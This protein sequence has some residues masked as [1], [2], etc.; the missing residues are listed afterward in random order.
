[1]GAEREAGP[2]PGVKVVL[3]IDTAARALLLADGPVL[4]KSGG[5]VDG[6]LVDALGAVDVVDAAVRGDGPETG[7]ARAGVVSA[8]VLDD[9]VLDE[10]VA[11][12]AVDG[13]VRVSV[14]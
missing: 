3:H 12:P 7:G 2:S 1:M 6:G 14:G 8:K 13:E 10:R 9:V 11:R 4:V 5:A